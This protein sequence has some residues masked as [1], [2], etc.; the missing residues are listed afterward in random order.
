MIDIGS[1]NPPS[2]VSAVSGAVACRSHLDELET[3]INAQPPGAVRNRSIILCRQIGLWLQ[4]K[5]M[6]LEHE[7]MARKCA[8]LERTKT[9]RVSTESSEHCVWPMPHVF[10]EVHRN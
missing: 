6:S 1:P 5:D 2:R 7:A 3:L 4:D 9:E 8:E 10:I